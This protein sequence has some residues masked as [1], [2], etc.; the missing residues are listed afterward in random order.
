MATTKI[1]SGAFPADVIN[2]A[3]IDDLA[4]THAKLHTTMDLSSKTVTLPTLNAKLVVVS[5]SS[6]EAINIR[7][8]SADDIGQLKFYENDGTTSLARLDSRT[9]HF[10]VGSYNELRFSAGGVGNSHVVIDT[11]GNIFFGANKTANLAQVGLQYT[12]AGSLAVTRDGGGAFNLNRLTSDGEILGLWKDTN[13][14]GYLGSNTSGGQSLLDISSEN[15]ASSNIRFLTYGSGSHNEVMR[16]ASSGNVGIGDPTASNLL[17][18]EGSDSG[19]FISIIN[20]THN[21][22]GNGL[23]VMGGD[24]ANTTAFRVTD[25]NNNLLFEVQGGGNVGIGP[26]STDSLISRVD[27]GYLSTRINNFNITS[28]TGAYAFTGVNI[29]QDTA[30]A[31]K[32]IDS[33]SSSSIHYWGDAIQFHLAPSG[34]ADATMAPSEKMRLTNGGRLGLGTNSPENYLHIKDE[35]VSNSHVSFIKLSHQVADLGGLGENGTFID[36]DFIDGNDNDRPQVSIGA[37]IGNRGAASDSGQIS[38]GRG[39]FIVKVSDGATPYNTDG[40]DLVEKFRV[41]WDGYVNAKAMP[42]ATT[43]ISSTSGT[44]VTGTGAVVVSASSVSV[45]KRNVG[46]S[47]FLYHIVLSS[48]TDGAVTNVNGFLRLEYKITSLGHTSFTATNKVIN[49]T[50]MSDYAGGTG[51]NTYTLLFTP[52][53]FSRGAGIEMRLIFSKSNAQ[54]VYFNQPGLA[55]QPSGTSNYAL[56]YVMEVPV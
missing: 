24:D 12:I 15:D 1:Q 43:E 10:E 50:S 7:G 16:L 20:N 5:P 28:G 8:R 26:G 54:S 22:N 46:R 18:V 37:E 51:Q 32:Y 11:S 53:D 42:I 49:T 36:F 3:S 41:N 33:T 44:N 23:K 9:T 48:E 19:N 56:G 35:Y 14:I 17:S 25:Y 6:A 47:R 4:V 29:Y 55:Q 52:P 45:T 34:T 27:Q 2:T 31:Y 40:S 13:K 30:G 39:A 21:S 38:E